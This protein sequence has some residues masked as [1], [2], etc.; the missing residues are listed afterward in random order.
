MT[1]EGTPVNELVDFIF[2][3]QMADKCE[4]STD[5]PNRGGQVRN[6]VFDKFLYL[7]YNTV[8]CFWRWHI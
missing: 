8:D 3:A 2:A 5:R 7:H 6:E 4:K 1:G